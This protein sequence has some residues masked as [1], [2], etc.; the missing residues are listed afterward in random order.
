MI[1]V[2]VL[3]PYTEGSRFDHEYYATK[4]LAL[5]QELYSDIM[6]GYE[7]LKGAPDPDG[8]PPAFEA[9]A[10]LKFTSREAYLE[11]RK[12]TRPQIVADAPNVTDIK[13]I[14]L[15]TEVAAEG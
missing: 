14:T 8:N 4:H 10:H 7:M 15:L 9:V 12:A 13:P 1:R 5:V 6:T 2:T 3:Y 11:R